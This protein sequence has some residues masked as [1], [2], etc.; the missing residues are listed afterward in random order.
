VAKKS[1]LKETEKLALKLIKSLGI[2]DCSVKVSRDKESE[3]I[4]IDLESESPGLL[5]GFRGKTLSALQLILGLMINAT[6]NEW[7]PIIVD[8]NDYRAEQKEK[9][10]GMAQAAAEK[11]KS[12]GRRVQLFPMSAYERR[13]VHVCLSEDPLVETTSEGEGEDRKII[14]TPKQ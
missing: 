7:Q 5:I 13:I 11:A 3:A 1:N 9:L 8:V 2:K 4:R 6:L 10:V 12:L 14:I